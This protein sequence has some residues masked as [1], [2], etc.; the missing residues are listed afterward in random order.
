MLFLSIPFLLL[1]ICTAKYETLNPKGLEAATNIAAACVEQ[2]IKVIIVH[3]KKKA[4]TNHSSAPLMP[5]HLS[6]FVDDLLGAGS[7]GHPQAKKYQ[8]NQGW[9]QYL[10]GN[11]ISTSSTGGTTTIAADKQQ[12]FEKIRYGFAATRC[13]VLKLNSII[14]ESLI[15]RGLAACPLHPFG[16]WTT[17]GGEVTQVRRW[18]LAPPL[19][20]LLLLHLLSPLIFRSPILT[21]FRINQLFNTLYTD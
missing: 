17:F 14:M 7:F 6:V 19:L 10:S 12:A 4:T 18:H 15:S 1:I 8:V 20:F 3:G 16:H 9:S 21:L 5:S 2:C 11:I 13:S